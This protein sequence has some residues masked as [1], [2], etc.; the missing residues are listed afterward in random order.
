M[1][2]VVK[3]NEGAWVLIGFVAFI[4]VIFIL[5]YMNA[6]GAFKNKNTKSASDG[7]AKEFKKRPD[8]KHH[9]T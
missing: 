6:N 5:L 2:E 3:I 1:N 4:A 7:F 8:E 9:T